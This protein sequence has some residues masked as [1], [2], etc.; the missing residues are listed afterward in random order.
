MEYG[1]PIKIKRAAILKKVKS[2]NMSYKIPHASVDG[3]ILLLPS[4]K[5]N[6]KAG[7]RLRKLVK[8]YTGG[9]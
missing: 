1:K 7:S 6:K 9:G 8:E 3:N 4:L 2:R 5:P